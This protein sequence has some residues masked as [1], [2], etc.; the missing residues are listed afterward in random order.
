MAELVI[1]IGL[2]GAGKTTFYHRHL[3]ATHLHVSGDLLRNRR[4][5]R[6]RQLAAIDQALAAGQSVTVDNVNATAADRGALIAVARRRGA[7]V[8]GYLFDVAPDE[9]LRRNRGRQPPARVPAVAIFA[10]RKRWQ[11][12]GPEE[13]FDRLHR[14]R[15]EAG[16]FASS[17][18]EVDRAGA[19][20]TVFLLSPASTSGER[21]SLVLRP[22]ASFPLAV[23]LR[24]GVGAPLGEV[25]SFLSGL[26]FRGKLTYAQ[27]FAL[28]PPGLCGA[29]VITPGEGLRDPAEPVTLTRLRR[30]VDVRIRPDEPRYTGPL[31]R[32]AGA[33]SVLAGERCRIVLLGSIASA[34]YVEPLVGVFGQRLLIPPAF[35]GRGDMSRGGLLLRCAQKGRELAYVPVVGAERH[36]PRPPRLPP[37]SR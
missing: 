8:V 27:T 4:D 19:L 32:D 33:L 29:F 15:A 20:P 3:A 11:E 14:I 26:Y 17:P 18:P 12:P 1:L 25:F 2:P 13:G 36:G 35:V 23:R 21:A 30:F 37:R 9:C 7:A 22:G 16:L 34:R 10:A 24:S 5:R 31:L 28:P 6:A